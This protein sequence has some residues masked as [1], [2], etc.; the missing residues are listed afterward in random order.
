MKARLH[1]MSSTVEPALSDIAPRGDNGPLSNETPA[2]APLVQTYPVLANPTVKSMVLRDGWHSLVT[3]EHQQHLRQHCIVCARWIVDPTALKRHLKQAHKDIWA[4][5]DKRLDEQCAELTGELIRDGIC[6]YCDRT[7][8]NRH[9]KQCNVIFQSAIA[10]LLFASQ[11]DGDRNTDADVSASAARPCV[12][13][14]AD[15]DAS[16]PCPSLLPWTARGCTQPNPAQHQSDILL[17]ATRPG[18]SPSPALQGEPGVAQEQDSRPGC[19]VSPH[20]DPECPHPGGNGQ[21]HHAREQPSGAGSRQASWPTERR[22]Q[23]A[24]SEMECREQEARSRCHSSPLDSGRGKRHP[25]RG[26]RARSAGHSY[27][28]SCFKADSSGAS[29]PGSSSLHSGDSVAERGR[30]QDACQAP[31]I[32]QSPRMGTGAR[33][34]A[35]TH[36]PAPWPSGGLAEGHPSG[37]RC[38]TLQRDIIQCRLENRNNTRYINASIISICWQMT[39]TNLEEALP[40][41]WKLQIRGRAWYP[42]NFLRLSLAAWRLPEAQHD[43]AEFLTYLLPRIMWYPTVFSWSVRYQIGDGLHREDHADVRLLHLNAPDGL[44]SSDLQ[45]T[46]DAWHHQRQLHALDSAPGI[47]LLQLPRFRQDGTG[48]C[49]KHGIPINIRR[50]FRFPVFTHEHGI[51]CR[52][53]EYTVQAALIHIESTMTAGHYRAALMD[54]GSSVDQ[55]WYTDDN[56]VATSVDL[57]HAVHIDEIYTNCYVLYCHTARPGGAGVGH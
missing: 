42:R 21:T 25:H 23:D 49:V 48:R 12:T 50:S 54:P 45:D 8:Y 1:A 15:P 11:D 39:M 24:I 34:T 32:V 5:I 46:I 27:Q 28:I 22:Q 33:A 56:R 13:N 47:L 6:P 40:Q 57:N 38:G 51:E 4:K 41:A 52:W 26:D 29:G 43:A 19:R 53:Q 31:N 16:R 20:H 37:S 2:P 36:A 14:L 44:I 35:R 9:F 10:G 3:S 55:L 7:S 17:T 30:R 18:L